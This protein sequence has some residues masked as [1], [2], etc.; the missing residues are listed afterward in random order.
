MPSIDIKDILSSSLPP[1]P[2]GPTGP[3]G[4]PQGPQGPQGVTGPTGPSGPSGSNDSANINFVQAGANAVTRTV[5]SKLR[6]AVSV[7]DFGADPT[8]SNNSV[9]AIQ[10]AINAANCVYFPAGTYL[11]NSAVTLKANTTVF[12]EGASSVILYNGSAASQGAF[13]V[14]SGSSSSYVDN[15]TISD[16]KFLGTVST[17][18]FSEF[19][20]LI[21]LSGVRNCVIER[22]V[23]EGFRG[24]GIYIGS[25]DLAEQERHN[26]NVTIR[27][28]YIDGVNNDNRNGISVIDGVGINI[29]NN[30]ITRCTR[31]NMPGAI[32]IEPDVNVYHIIRDISIRNNRIIN[33]GGNVGNI[34]VYLP[35]VNYTVMPTGFNFENNYIENASAS[36][37]GI[38]FT[39][40]NDASPALTESISDFGIRISKN[41]VKFGSTGRGFGIGNGND[42]VFDSNDFIGGTT[43]LLGYPNMNFLDVIFKNNLFADVQSGIDPF[44]ISVFTGSRLKFEGNIFKDCGPSSGSI[45]G[46]LEFNTGTTS[47]VDVIGNIFASP[48]GAFTKQAIRNAGHTFTSATNLI[49]DNKFIAGVNQFEG[50]DIAA[51]A[52]T[53]ANTARN[54]SNSI[55]AF[56]NR[57]ND[58]QP[59]WY[60]P[61]QFRSDFK[62]NTTDGLNDG[63]TFHGVLTLRTYGT[64]SDLSG[65]PV[66]QLG[67]T[68]AG[69][70][71]IRQS[72]N[73]AAWGSWSQFAKVAN[74]VTS[75]AASVYN[76]TVGGTNRDLFVD[77]AGVIGYVSSVRES[78]T[79]IES[80]N[81]VNWVLELDPVKFNRRK[82]DEEGNYIEEAYSEIEYGLI[83][84]EVETIAPEICF[85]DEVGEGQE[86]RGVHYHKLITPMLKLIQEQQ[87]TID[88][89]KTRISQLENS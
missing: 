77:D 60:T 28:C 18:G 68:D 85:Y 73:A 69:N 12:G 37:Y 46:S 63:G 31:S 76:T 14:N 27:D 80:L 15:I 38:Y 82:K 58:E 24:D 7:V 55:V 79:N 54:S 16:L 49:S 71:W 78:K 47:Y 62:L 22:C 41:I 42:I 30:Y 56:D 13:F 26:I 17:L 4:G 39:Y 23:V 88:E 6:D 57:N 9:A 19:I 2:Q 45:G 11:L 64:G 8:G 81:D 3:A 70:L 20:H 72:T 50:V 75:V 65:G 33:C 48:T 32:D 35:R 1:G 51:S 29:D 53:Q 25:G 87:K 61:A 44:A 40:G 67:V 59:Q 84:E 10:S 89:L 52:Y 74:S 36:N 5:Q 43:S 83:A 66:K 34:S 21:S 86:L